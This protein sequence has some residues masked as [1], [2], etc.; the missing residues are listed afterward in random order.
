MCKGITH[1]PDSYHFLKGGSQIQPFHVICIKPG[2]L[3]AIEKTCI[4]E[5]IS[6]TNKTSKLWE[7]EGKSKEEL[8]WKLNIW[9]I[10]WAKGLTQF[11]S[12]SVHWTLKC[13]LHTL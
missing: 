1:H 12:P 3:H 5:K 10:I 2:M 13:D 8:F 6:E 9:Q 7:K 11:N 4:K